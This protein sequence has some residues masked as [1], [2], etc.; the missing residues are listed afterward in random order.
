[1][2]GEA[3]LTLRKAR[4][5]T[6]HAEQLGPYDKWFVA[7]LEAA[8]AFGHSVVEH[9]H[10]EYTDRPGFD[11]WETAQKARLGAFVG[12]LYDTRNL[13]LHQG[14]V[15]V[16]RIVSYS[17]TLSARTHVSASITVVHGLPWY[18]RSIKTLLQDCTYPI[19][20]RV[21]R[22]RESQ[23]LKRERAAVFATATPA[24]TVIA[25]GLYFADPQWQ[26]RS[27]LAL[28]RQHFDELE[29]IIADAEA[30]F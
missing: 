14:P 17:V 29:M 15:P 28:L 18:Q 11:R 4:Y 3:R 26:D 12:F 30:R 25:D 9:L 13:V 21:C 2:P 1:M 8:I 10:K 20:E 7:N 24:A 19:R 6:D 27:A 5:F 16:K 23:R 22:W